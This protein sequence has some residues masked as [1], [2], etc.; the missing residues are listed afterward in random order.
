MYTDPDFLAFLRKKTALENMRHS[1]SSLNTFATERQNNEKSGLNSNRIS[2]EQD[3]VKLFPPDVRFK[4][5]RILNEIRTRPDIISWEPFTHEMIAFQK[6]CPG[7][8]IIDIISFF[9][10]MSTRAYSSENELLSSFGKNR[11][12]KS[13]PLDAELFLQGMQEILGREKDL[14]NFTIMFDRERVVLIESLFERQNARGIISRFYEEEKK[15]DQKFMESIP[16]DI[17]RK[18]RHKESLKETEKDLEKATDEYNKEISEATNNWGEKRT[19]MNQDFQAQANALSK[20]VLVLDSIF[21]KYAKKWQEDNKIMESALQKEKEKP[22]PD[23]VKIQEYEDALATHMANYRES[24][25]DYENKRKTYKATE[26]SITNEFGNMQK[27]FTKLEKAEMKAIREKHRV[28]LNELKAA[29]TNAK[30]NVARDNISKYQPKRSDIGAFIKKTRLKFP[31]RGPAVPTIT[32]DLLLESAAPYIQDELS[33]IDNELL[34]FP[35]EREDFGAAS[36]LSAPPSPPPLGE[37]IV[38]EDPTPS[39]SEEEEEEPEEG[40]LTLVAEGTQQH[41]QQQL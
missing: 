20:E 27:K 1:S 23:E 26:S 41:Q 12:D 33:G 8:N 3:L 17:E 7:S 32:H 10:G 39:A 14:K 31:E 21:N 29:H 40:E 28:P 25:K 37:I 22:Q 24:R 36:D 13:I 18:K 19:K 9:I 38:P 11:D 2:K 15:K 4:V 30:R 35:P 5:Y 6:L 34:L 16:V